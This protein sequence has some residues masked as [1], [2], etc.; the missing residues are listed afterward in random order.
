MQQLFHSTLLFQEGNVIPG[1]NGIPVALLLTS[2]KALQLLSL[3]TY[4]TSVLMGDITSVWYATVD[5]WL[6]KCLAFRTSFQSCN[7]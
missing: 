7:D 2:V 4:R 6:S 3:V 5:A 1:L